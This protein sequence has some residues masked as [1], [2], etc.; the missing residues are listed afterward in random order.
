MALR[1][2]YEIQ[3]TFN[4]FSIIR[5]MQLRDKAKGIPCPNLNLPREV[6]PRC[7][8]LLQWNLY[9]VELNAQ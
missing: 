6:H 8:K 3:S 2:L 4:Y 5:K 7:G 1:Q 9:N